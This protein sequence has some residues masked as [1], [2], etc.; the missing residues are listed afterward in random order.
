MRMLRIDYVTAKREGLSK[1]HQRQVCWQASIA[2]E[3]FSNLVEVRLQWHDEYL[4]EEVSA[5][6]NVDYKVT[7]K[8][9]SMHSMSRS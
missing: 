9:T 6:A 5:T 2:P 3:S 4:I 8:E 7:S 1:L